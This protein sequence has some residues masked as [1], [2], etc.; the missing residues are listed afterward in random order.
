MVAAAFWGSGRSRQEWRSMVTTESIRRLAI[1]VESLWSEYGKLT[2]SNSRDA[3]NQV[4]HF[5]DELATFAIYDADKTPVYYWRNQAFTGLSPN[6]NLSPQY[7]VLHE[8]EIIGWVACVPSDFYFISANRSIVVR[9]T[10]TLI[11]G[12]IISIAAAVL[13]CLAASPLHAQSTSAKARKPLVTAS[14]VPVGAN[15]DSCTFR[16]DTN[17]GCAA[18]VDAND[19][20]DA[21]W[22]TGKT[23]QPL[24]H[25]KYAAIRAHMRRVPRLE[26]A[27][28]SSTIQPRVLVRWAE[29]RPPARCALPPRMGRE[30]R[31]AGEHEL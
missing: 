28:E 15:S 11:V 14:L 25:R 8:D 6:H 12:M 13:A 30:H 23:V 27:K 4:T 19:F 2:P 5:A 26:T 29:C 1:V 7:A 18:A 3:M 22:C 10:Q 24:G 20:A 17:G 21:T 16:D 31:R 9:M